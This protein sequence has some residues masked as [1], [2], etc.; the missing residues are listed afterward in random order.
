MTSARRSNLIEQ[1]N[2]LRTQIDSLA[3][4]AGFNGVNLLQGDKVSIAFNEKGGKNQTK[5]DIQGTSLSADNIG[6]AQAGNA[7]VAGTINFQTTP[8]WKKPPRP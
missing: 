7:Q 5:L 3:K 4:D 1:Y 2:T 8:I 6:I